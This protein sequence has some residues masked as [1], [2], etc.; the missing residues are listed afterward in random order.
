MGEERG[1]RRVGRV[2]GCVRTVV[3]WAEELEGRISVRL[4]KDEE[5][6]QINAPALISKC[7]RKRER[8]THGTPAIPAAGPAPTDNLPPATSSIPPLPTTPPTPPP[9]LPL[10]VAALP[11]ARWNMNA[12]NGLISLGA[13][14]SNGLLAPAAIL[15]RGEE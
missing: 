3:V 2:G 8:A 6:R 13:S 7:R 15:G 9:P 5:R 14:Q 4:E 1:G 11:G 10:F 12:S